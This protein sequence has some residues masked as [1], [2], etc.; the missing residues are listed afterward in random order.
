MGGTRKQQITFL[1]NW[2][3]KKKRAQNEEE[4]FEI[5][6]IYEVQCYGEFDIHREAQE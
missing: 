4:T 2:K 5:S 1:E 3:Q 6:W